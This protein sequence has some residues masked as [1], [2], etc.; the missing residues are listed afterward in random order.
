MIILGQG[1]D[2]DH[3]FLLEVE[4]QALKALYLSSYHDQ[5]IPLASSGLGLQQ[6]ALSLR[7]RHGEN[8]AREYA[9]PN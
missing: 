7:H 8:G 9:R 6:L 2:M 1:L 3:L 5:C 4:E